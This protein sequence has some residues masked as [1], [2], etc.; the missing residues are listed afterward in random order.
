MRLELLGELYRELL[1]YRSLG[2]SPFI[3]Q[4]TRAY[5]RSRYMARRSPMGMSERR[6]RTCQLVRALADLVGTVR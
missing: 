2:S 6:E 4:I 1:S 5:V 3:D